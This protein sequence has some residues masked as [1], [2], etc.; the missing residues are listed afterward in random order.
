[1]SLQQETEN[2]SYQI[3]N[4]KK[5]II[6]TE[7]GDAERFRVVVM[8]KEGAISL[9]LSKAAKYLD[10]ASDTK[11]GRPSNEKLIANIQE[12]QVATLK[13]F[14]TD[15]PEFSFPSENEDVWW[16]V[17][18]RRTNNNTEQLQ[19][20]YQNLEELG[21]QIGIQTLQFQE[22]TVKLVKGTSFQ[23]AGSFLFLDN[24][25]ELRKP[26]QLN[27]FI[28]SEQVDISEKNEWV[29]DLKRRTEFSVGENSVII[30][31]LDSGINNKHPLLIDIIPD[32]RLYSYKPDWGAEDTWQNG[33][34]GT[35]MSGLALYGD[36]TQALA[37][38][39]AIRIYHGVESYKIIHPADPNAPELYGSIT[40]EAVN[41]PIV[42]NPNNLRIYCIAITDKDCV[43]RLN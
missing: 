9:F 42:D 39:D 16:E 15:E 37:T 31:L 2:P 4:I 11:K 36:L 38:R 14:W 1:M 41:T 12:I 13:S 3:L 25:A 40:I 19:K 43:R 27:D 28:T 20:V 23:L 22:H 5:E 32:S 34:H 7:N 35:G 33:G 21:A 30:C 17:W 18:F 24:L 10:P 29:E 6:T 8:M 26:Q